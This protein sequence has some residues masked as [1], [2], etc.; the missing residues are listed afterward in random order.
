MNRFLKNIKYYQFLELYYWLKTNLRIQILRLYYI[1][2]LNSTLFRRCQR[3]LLFVLYIKNGRYKY[4]EIH[5]WVPSVNP[6]GNYARIRL[7]FIHYSNF[8][9]YFIR[10]YVNFSFRYLLVMLNVCK[11]KYLLHRATSVKFSIQNFKV[12]VLIYTLIW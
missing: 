11:K 10:K 6:I 7:F 2:Q 5:V 4:L 12:E 1:G 3:F 8:L 9:L